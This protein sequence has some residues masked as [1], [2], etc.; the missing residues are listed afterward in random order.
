MVIGGMLEVVV[1][2][3]VVVVVGHWQWAADMAV[4][5]VVARCWAV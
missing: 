3:R 4:V 2:V 1:A 5:R